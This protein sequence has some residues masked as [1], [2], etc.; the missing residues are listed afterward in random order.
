MTDPT[1]PAP[2][3]PSAG[4]A[5][6][7]LYKGLV[8]LTFTKFITIKFAAVIYVIGIAVSVLGW[9]FGVFAAFQSGAGFGFAALLLG[10]IFPLISVIVMRVY[11]E[12]AVSLV[13]TAQNT[14]R[15]ADRA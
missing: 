10:W 3:A 9:I 12:L 7:G 14:S 11:L 1:F 2:P 15:L 6:D 4:D 8:D 13:R 5:V